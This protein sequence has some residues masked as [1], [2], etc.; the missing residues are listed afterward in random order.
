MSVSTPE[1]LRSVYGIW[2]DDRGKVERAVR[3]LRDRVVAD[4]GMPAE[5]F[6]ASQSPGTDVVAACET[7]SFGGVRL[8]LVRACESWRTDD[9]APIVAYLAA[10]NP[11]TCLA[12]VA[13]G[14]VTPKLKEAIAAAGQV[15]A[16][17]PDAKAKRADRTKWFV[18]HVQAECDRAG[19]KLPPKLA[20]SVVDRVGEDA[21]ALSREAEKL[22]AAAGREPIDAEL[23]D[24]LVVENPEAKAYELADA[25]VA[26]QASRVY[27]LLG[28]LASGDRPTDPAVVHSTLTRH[29]RGI[30]VA[31]ALGP[32]ASPD[33]IG[34]ATGL[35]GYPAQKAAEHAR[36]VPA[37]VGDRCVSRLA[38]L[39]LDLRV[40]SL[41]SLGRTND[42]GRRFVL[43]R[44]ARDLVAVTRGD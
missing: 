36:A 10:P 16:Y 12:L 3:R 7:L 2:G 4:G 24:A 5:A 42:D 22:A 38:T 17:G 33:A 20:R 15:L 32:G 13:D 26:G 8:V 23:V 18:D 44:A 43:E 1:G 19:A 14:A 11:G 9:A 27:R 40:S 31:Q 28:E 30:A 25:I 34:E 35:K 37:G 6:D 29:F 41:A 39:E 21:M